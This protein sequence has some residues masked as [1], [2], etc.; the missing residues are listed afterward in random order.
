MNSSLHNESNQIV[1]NENAGYVYC[2]S[3]LSLHTID[4]TPI[5][6]IGKTVRDPAVR[7]HELSTTTSV[8]SPFK[9]EFA[10]LVDNRNY[11]ESLIHKIL[12]QDRINPGREF[13]T[14]KIDEIEDIFNLK[15]GYGVKKKEHEKCSNKYNN[16]PINTIN[17]GLRDIIEDG[18]EIRHT[19]KNDLWVGKYNRELDVIIYKNNNYNSPSGFTKAHK[20]TVSPDSGLTHS[21]N[22]WTDAKIKINDKWITLE[23]H[24]KN[25]T[26]N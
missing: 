11:T 16:L 2:L 15:E 25:I 3:N 19:Y 5:Y 13:F 21:S 18:T 8:P 9:V 14:T 22:G 20:Q 23:V 7:A 24:R 4:G 6:K 12:K 17:K 1:A 26:N 10:I